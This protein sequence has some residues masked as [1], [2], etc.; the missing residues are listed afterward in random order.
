M[1]ALAPLQQAIYTR[2]DNDGPLA[3]LGFG[4]Y[5]EPPG[6]GQSDRYVA[7]GEATEVRGGFTTTESQS[8]DSRECT[9]TLHVWTKGFST[10][11]CKQGMALVCEALEGAPL[12]VAGWGTGT[13][14]CEFSTFMRDKQGDEMWRHGVLRFRVVVGRLRTAS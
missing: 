14:R 12:A 4:V 9:E 13:A 1:N 10:F 8:H 3:A 11:A 5:D 2:L 6:G 7:I